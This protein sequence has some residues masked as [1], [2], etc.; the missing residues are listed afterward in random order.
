MVLMCESRLQLIEAY[1]FINVYFCQSNYSYLVV[2]YI[3]SCL[4]HTK[5]V[6]LYNYSIID[7]MK[8]YESPLLARS[9]INIVNQR[10]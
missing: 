7:Y 10:I 9:G 5:F 2:T 3:F 8:I 4:C 1:F 6:H